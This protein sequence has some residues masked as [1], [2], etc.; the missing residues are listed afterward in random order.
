MYCEIDSLVYGSVRS[1]IIATL[2]ENEQ[3]RLY[4]IN[5]TDN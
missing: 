4:A 1:R 3:K 2:D 5:N